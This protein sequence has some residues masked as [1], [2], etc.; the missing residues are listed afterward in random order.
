[1][2]V[3]LDLVPAPLPHHPVERRGSGAARWRV[4]QVA[5]ARWMAVVLDLVPTSLRCCS[6]SDAIRGGWGR[7]SASLSFE[8]QHVPSPA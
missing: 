3:V 8:V 5:G 6:G 1:M 7:S 2:A 4:D